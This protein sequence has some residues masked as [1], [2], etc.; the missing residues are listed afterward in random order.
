MTLK[1]AAMARFSFSS[2]HWRSPSQHARSA[3]TARNF[4][5]VSVCL[6]LLVLSRF[7]VVLVPGL[8]RRKGLSPAFRICELFRFQKLRKFKSRSVNFPFRWFRQRI[9]CR[10]E[11][12]INTI[13][14]RAGHDLVG[15]AQS[16][17][18]HRFQKSVF[19]KSSALRA[20]PNEDS[21]DRLG[22]IR[23][24]CLW[25]FGPIPRRGMALEPLNSEI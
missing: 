14:M 1:P 20:F 3:I 23:G 11:R 6:I 10:T 15:A 4:S 21:K 19:S 18:L 2:L 5:V 12:N 24:H 13:T 8:S 16:S 22:Q 9:A 17:V 25:D 7:S